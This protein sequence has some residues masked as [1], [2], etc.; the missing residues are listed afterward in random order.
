MELAYER[1]ESLSDEISSDS[2]SLILRHTDSEKVT[3]AL[4]S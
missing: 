2:P 1:L 4:V 3:C